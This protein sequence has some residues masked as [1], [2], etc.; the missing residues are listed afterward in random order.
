VKDCA[1][2][3]AGEETWNGAVVASDAPTRGNN[4]W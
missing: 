3:W 4:L 2:S 1:G